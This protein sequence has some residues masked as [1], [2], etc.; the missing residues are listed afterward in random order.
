MATTALF[1]VVDALVTIFDT[2]LAITVYDGP[3]ATDAN[4]QQYAAVG[5]DGDPTSTGQAGDAQQ[6]WAPRANT[7][8]FSRDDRGT[9]RCVVVAWSGDSVVAARRT[10]TKGYLA[11]I[12]NALRADP[13]L[14]GVV[15]AAGITD[16]GL[17]QE[18]SDGGN[19]VRIPFT[20]TYMARI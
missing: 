18:V 2:A 9:V 19:T 5:W 10:A 16:I 4:L 11:S 1:A 6:D 12:E 15:I 13:S 7:G 8:L 3:Q 20:V 17:I 14:G